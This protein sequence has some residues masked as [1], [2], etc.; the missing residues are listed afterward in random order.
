MSAARAAPRRK[1][2]AFGF[3]LLEVLVA[4]AIM[5]TLSVTAYRALSGMLDGEARVAQERDRWRDLDLFFARFEH[6]VGHMLPRAYSLGDTAFPAVFLRGDTLAFVR[7]TPGEPPRRIGYRFREGTIELLYWPGLD[8]PGA[9]DPVA[10]G[11]A[12]DL[13]GWHVRFANREGIWLDSWGNAGPQQDDA[14]LPRAMHV[15]L[16]LADGTRVERVFA[17]R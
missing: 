13:A 15:A 1:A 16:D 14:P 17:L 6:D 4:L 7:G 5:A 3:T 8:A 9:T 12:S 11:V 2:R 10:Y